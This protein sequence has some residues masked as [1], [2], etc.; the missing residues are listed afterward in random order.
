MELDLSA[1][2]LV[3][4]GGAVAFIAVGLL[5]LAS[6]GGGA[7]RV[8]L[9]AACLA[10]GVNFVISN[11]LETSTLEEYLLK[12]APWPLVTLAAGAFFLALARPAPARERAVIVALG[13]AG[14]LSWAYYAWTIDAI[15]VA[16]AYG[17]PPGE[18]SE[19]WGRR[20]APVFVISVGAYA[21]F[22]FVAA[23]ASFARPG[24]SPRAAAYLALAFGGY[25]AFNAIRLQP[26]GVATGDEGP[27][28]VALLAALF[29][30]PR[31]DQGEPRLRLTVLFALL[32]LM[33]AGQ[34]VGMIGVRQ[35]LSP[36]D[37]F[38]TNGVARTAGAL[39]LALAILRERVFG[40][41][42]PRFALR[43]GPLAAGALALLFIVAQI[44][45]QFLSAQYGLLMGGVVA[46]ALLFAAQPIQRAVERVN[47]RPLAPATADAADGDRRE[48]LYRDALRITLKDRRITRAEELHLAH[49]ADELGLS[50]GRAMELRHDVEADLTRAER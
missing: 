13:I 36:S 47:E 1:A 27:W 12:Q 23:V 22:S 24:V 25:S 8:L 45:Q 7:R 37:D 49:L 18:L 42:P 26:Y 28:I 29:W 40:M 48:R 39:L 38:G 21:F 41:E 19:I 6:R 16:L 31:R 20:I 35:G 30:L 50:A 3:N 44:A 17:L 9:A 43:R 34:I 4:A 14:L 15:A 10:Y 11:L 33:L 46:G 5:A 32:G 2:S